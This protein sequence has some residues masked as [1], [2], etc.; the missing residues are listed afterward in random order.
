MQAGGRINHLE[1]QGANGGGRPRISPRKQDAGDA[2]QLRGDVGRRIRA[3]RDHDHRGAI[4][5]A[6]D[7]KGRRRYRGYAEL[8]PRAHSVVIGHPR[9]SHRKRNRSDV[10]LSAAGP[11]DGHGVGPG[12]RTGSGC[13]G[14]R[15]RPGRRVRGETAGSI[16]GQAA[17]TQGD[18]A[19]KA[20]G[21]SDRGAV[22]RHAALRHRLTRGCPAQ[23]EVGRRRGGYRQRDRGRTGQSAADS[24]DG[25]RV[26]PGRRARTGR[27]REC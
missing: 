4:G 16:T 14:E 21:R 9:A 3:H 17:Y 22:T 25:E 5:P 26:G 23:G 15:R 27:Y 2:A 24:G 18:L 8:D 11:G 7:D 19:G 20:A 10:G 13:Y 6:A 1:D 12:R